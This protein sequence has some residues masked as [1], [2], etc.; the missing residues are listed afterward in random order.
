MRAPRTVT[1]F[2]TTVRHECCSTLLPCMQRLCRKGVAAPKQDLQYASMALCM[3]SLC[4]ALL[5]TGAHAACA[6][7][8]CACCSCHCFG[9]SWETCVSQNRQLIKDAV[10]QVSHASEFQVQTSGD[11]ALASL[12]FEMHEVC[13]QQPWVQAKCGLT[14]KKGAGG[15]FTWGKVL[16]DDAGG[17][18]VRSVHHEVQRCGRCMCPELHQELCSASFTSQPWRLRF[19]FALGVQHHIVT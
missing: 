4:T 9:C 3:S 16:T 11:R 19:V 7:A 8:A 15:K 12:S 6:P 17:P 14:K 5:A 10:A 1:H 18:Q 2:R 13:K